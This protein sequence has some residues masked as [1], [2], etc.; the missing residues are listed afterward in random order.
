LGDFYIGIAKGSENFILCIEL[1][2]A[3]FST[4]PSECMNENTC[5][6]PLTLDCSESEKNAIEM[7]KFYAKKK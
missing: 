6:P 1:D 2:D 4:P 5:K 3:P 7:S